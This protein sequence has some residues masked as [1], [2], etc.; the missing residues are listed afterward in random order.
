MSYWIHTYQQEMLAL[1]EKIESHQVQGNKR[2]A[3]GLARDRQELVRKLGWRYRQQDGLREE[4]ERF[5]IRPAYK[6]MARILN[7]PLGT[8]CSRVARA[9]EEFAHRLTEARETQT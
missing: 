7:L 3:N 4:F 8:V 5:D 6:D 2:A 1:D 9:R